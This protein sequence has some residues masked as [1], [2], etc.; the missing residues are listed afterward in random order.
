MYAFILTVEKDKSKLSLLED[1]TERLVCEW[2]ESRDMGA[3][4]FQAIN[5]LLQERGIEAD[6]VDNFSVDVR[7]PETYT[8][9][10]IAE[11]VA[12]TY[13]FAIRS[14]PH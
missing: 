14:V 1:N 10:R 4:L 2:E 5:D 11:T 12:K 13:G 3:R 8:S 6:E 7:I 9:G